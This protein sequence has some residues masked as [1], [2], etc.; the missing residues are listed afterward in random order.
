MNMKVFFRNLIQRCTMTVNDAVAKR[1][2][3]LLAEKN[4][5]Q[6]RLEQLSGIQHGHMQWI[7][8]GK[9]KTVTLSTVMMIAHGFGMTVLE[10]LNDDSFLYENL[11]VE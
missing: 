5:T 2:A 7:M 6:Y 4:M 9:S 8:S 11:D 1:I 10:F 3:K